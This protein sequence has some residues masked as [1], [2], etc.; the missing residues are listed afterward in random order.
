MLTRRRLLQLSGT[1]ALAACSP[2]TQGQPEPAADPGELVTHTYKRVGGLEIKADVR[3]GAGEGPSPVA[4]WIHGGALIN[5]SRQGEANIGGLED[6]LFE[7]GFVL[8]SI[9]YRLAPET[10]LA[11]IIEDLEDAFGWIAEA[12]PGLF[13]ADP[14]RIV[15]LGRSAG[16]Y[17]ALTAGYRAHPRPR[18]VVSFWGYG[19]LIGPWYSEPSPHERHWR[20]EMSEQ[21]AQALASG[22]PVAN[23]RDRNGD[24]GAF[25]S[26]CRQK[27]VWPQQVAS[28][29]PHEEPEKFAPYMP[30]ENVT[31]EYPPTLLVHGTA[32]TDVPFEQSRMMAERLERHGV[33]HELIAID[34]AEH[35]LAGAG[36]GVLDDVARTA[37][38]FVQAQT[39]RTESI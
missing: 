31:L 5:G 3:R 16:G 23:A 35:G 19:D 34:G 26:Y 22:P 2:S 25:Y 33:E 24:G 27:G 11:A 15:A 18:A 13:G 37:V 12:G 39:K 38:D 1:A 6:R 29:D 10:K 17:L 14:E 20:S 32:D 28:W 7:A 4:V 30:L 21:Q 8:V 36:A 9:D